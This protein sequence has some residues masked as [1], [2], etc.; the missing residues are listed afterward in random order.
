MVYKEMNQLIEKY[1]EGNTSL[2]EEQ[3]LKS[4]FNGTDVDE[5]LAEYQPIFQYFTSQQQVTLDDQFDEKLMAMIDE[6]TGRRSILRP[7]NN[8]VVRI[9]AAIVLTLGVWWLI[10]TE[11]VTPAQASTID[12]TQYEPETPEEALKILRTALARTSKELN[13]GASV[14]AGEVTKISEIGKFVK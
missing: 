14:A 8:W 6:N 9:A 11:P 4:Y 12:W 7:L 5:R 10:P 3:T 2:E 1:F 13:E